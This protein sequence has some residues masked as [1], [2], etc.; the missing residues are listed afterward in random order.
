MS[1]L[2]VFVSG[3]MIGIY[4]DQS[5]KVPSINKYVQDIKDILKRHEKK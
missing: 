4:L 5:Y 3:I 2:L 1:K